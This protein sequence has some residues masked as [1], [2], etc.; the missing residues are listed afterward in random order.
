M[1]KIRNWNWGGFLFVVI[2]CCL[3]FLSNNNIPD[4]KSCFLA[5]FIFGVPFGLLFAYFSRSND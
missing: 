4:I 2:L 3:G 5:T 1:K